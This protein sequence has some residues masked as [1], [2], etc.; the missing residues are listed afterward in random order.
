M[1]PFDSQAYV[2]QLLV[3]LLVTI[4]FGGSV[5]LGTV[6]MR[7]QISVVADH[8]AAL[9]R[10]ISD[11]ER[12]IA[13]TSAL[14][15]E[16]MS[17]QVL[18]AQNDSMRLGLAEITQ[19]QIQP[20]IGDP[21][22]RLVARASR[23]AFEREALESSVPRFQLTLQPTTT[24]PATAGISTPSSVSFGLPAVPP[25]DAATSAR[26]GAVKFAFTP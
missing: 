13:D 22:R 2:N 11:V 19:T 21:A 18:R 20:V 25:A 5:G 17:P 8:N 16:A 26:P 1:K 23:R 12:Q 6:W 4:G 14:V 24:A 15:E 9:V 3:G 7:H 10:Q